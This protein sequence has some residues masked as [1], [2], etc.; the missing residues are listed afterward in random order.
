MNKDPTSDAN[1]HIAIFKTFAFCNK[2]R[3]MIIRNTPQ[4]H[5]ASAE[6][7][8]HLQIT[9]K[10]H[11]VILFQMSEGLPVVLEVIFC[12]YFST[13]LPF[14]IP[15]PSQPPSFAKTEVSLVVI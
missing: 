5:S 9:F 14:L 13:L 7:S 10:I 12:I 4:E 1:I 11:L 15:D 8:S 2:H 6:F 3:T